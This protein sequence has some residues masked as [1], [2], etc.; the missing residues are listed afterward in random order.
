MCTYLVNFQNRIRQG[1]NALDKLYN[2][3]QQIRQ[4]PI[5]HLGQKS[6]QLL[7]AYIDGYVQYH[8]E[9]SDESKCFFLPKFQE[10]V[11][12]HY[13]ISKTHSWVPLITFY[14]SS[15][16]NAFDNFYE[17]LDE[18]FSESEQ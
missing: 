9:I 8:V 10:Y 12:Q 14:S 5:I 13:N 15:D 6:L 4:N 17:L 11:Q 2:Q 7:K 16:A 3:L 18:F 1:E